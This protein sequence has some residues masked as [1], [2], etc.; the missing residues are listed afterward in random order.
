MNRSEEQVYALLAE[1]NPIPDGTAIPET[2]TAAPHL[3]LV[4]PRRD[5]MQTQA[6]PIRPDLKPTEPPR[7]RWVPALAAALIMIVAI[8]VAAL[9][10]RG[11]DTGPVAT[12]EVPPTTIT[13]SVDPN[14]AGEAVARQAIA[15]WN[16]GDPEVFLAHFALDGQIQEGAISDAG[17]RQDI[18]FSMALQQQSTVATC[19]SADGSVTCTTATTDALS[20]PVGVETETTWS[21]Q[22]EDGAITSLERSWDAADTGIILSMAAW[23]EANH[24]EV[25]A[26]TFAADCSSSV[27]Y[28][29][30]ANTW[31]ASHEAGNEM[32]TLAPE[33]LS[34]P[35]VQLA[36]QFIADWNAGDAAALF[37]SLAPTAEFSGIPASDPFLRADIEFYMA[38]ENRA[39]IE[40]CVPD[41]GTNRVP[42][43]ITEHQSVTCTAVTTDAISGPLGVSAEMDWIFRVDEGAITNFQWEWA[44][45]ALHPVDVVTDMVDWVEINHP[46]VFEA[47]FAAI[48]SSATEY[49][50]YFDRWAATPEGG[51]ALIELADEFR[52]QADY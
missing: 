30:K 52:A 14:A 4:D 46:D 21:F 17:V 47:S 13:E 1:A 51:A 39:A 23:I 20:G 16:A 44:E 22:I 11:Q 8:G 34:Q 3:S 7:R 18:A 2:L 37:A 26:A 32:L 43:L 27:D 29:C 35:S 36:R 41:I 9:A 31:L 49:N 45:E 48:C 5:D 15:D 10:F 6:R 50:C 40:H 28:N 42:P 24:P 12:T 38:G 25:W 19:S 33:Y